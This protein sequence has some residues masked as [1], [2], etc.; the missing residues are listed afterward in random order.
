MSSTSIIDLYI[1]PLEIKIDDDRAHITLRQYVDHGLRFYSMAVLLDDTTLLETLLYGTTNDQP[2]IDL[3]APQWE[4]K[5]YATSLRIEHERFVV[6]DEAVEIEEDRLAR[7]EP[8]PRYAR[9][10]VRSNRARNRSL[11][12]EQSTADLDG[13]NLQ[14]R[15]LEEILTEI[16]NMA[17]NPPVPMALNAFAQT[18][19]FV[20]DIEG[21]S[22]LLEQINIE[23]LDVPATLTDDEAQLEHIPMAVTSVSLPPFAGFSEG[24]RMC[25][26]PSIY[27]SMVTT[28]IT[29]L[30]ENVSGRVRLAKSRL[31]RSVAAEIILAE[32][33]W[34][35]KQPSDSQETQRTKDKVQPAGL[36]WDLPM[37]ASQNL[38]QDLPVAQSLKAPT[39]PSSLPTPSPTATPSVNTTSRFTSSFAAPEINRLSQYTTF[40]NP[41]P[42]PPLPRSL[43]NVLSH[44]NVGDDPATYDW[45]S[46]TRQK[47]RLNE[48]EDEDEETH[49]MSEK[50][51]ERMRRRAERHIQRQRK[52]AAASQAQQLASSQVPVVLSNSQPALIQPA[53][54]S[55]GAI[56]GSSQ[57]VDPNR[58]VASQV[59]Q[60]R[61]G[62]RPPPK[63]KRK[64]GF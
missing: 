37:R 16:S 17:V 39:L 31:A 59:L 38:S 3:V 21:A 45:R 9:R 58:L 48:L 15:S 20:E 25:N 36:T 28:W 63:K 18:E 4:R 52:E 61:Y 46:A 47:N 2:Q 26:L 34:I 5:T 19:I 1:H 8:I 62:G 57:S 23:R 29:P 35:A 51:R 40:N 49:E 14:T 33:F 64:S 56:P 42:I 55:Q 27:H 43:R 50:E 10:P 13:R 44:W 6:R 30:S 12:F 11:D 54:Q 22:L 53:R 24:E 41:S 7:T 32:K 60:G